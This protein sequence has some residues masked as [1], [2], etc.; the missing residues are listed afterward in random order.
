MCSSVNYFFFHCW[1]LLT[2]PSVI[3]PSNELLASPVTP[4]WAVVA[5]LLTACTSQVASAHVKLALFYDWL[6]YDPKVDNIMDI[7]PAALL[8][9]NSAPTHPQVLNRC[10]RFTLLSRCSPPCWTSSCAWSLPSSLPPPPAPGCCRPGP[11]SSTGDCCCFV[12]LRT[13]PAAGWCRGWSPSWPWH[14]GSCGCR[15]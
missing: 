13:L 2:S 1:T 11:T 10:P 12:P 4:R 5:G 3:H 15:P 9:H 6:F 14:P 7:E 8:L